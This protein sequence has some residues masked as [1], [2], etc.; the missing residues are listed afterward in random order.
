[1][2]DIE[3]TPRTIGKSGPRVSA[4]TL[5]TSAWRE[6]I[7]AGRDPRAVLDRVLD[8]GTAPW[9]TS[10][11][12]S[13][14]Y[15]DGVS[16]TIIGS[17]VAGTVPESMLIATKLD[18]DPETGDFSGA[19]LRRSLEESLERLGLDRVPVLHLHD[20]NELGYAEAF[21]PNGAIDAIVRMRREG[22][23]DRIGISG[24]W[25]PMLVQ[26]AATGLFDAVVTHNRYTLVDR[27]A[28]GL[29]RL[30][31]ERGI[32]VFNAAPYGSAPLAKWPAPVDRYAY[33]PAHPELAAAVDA[34]GR[35]ALEAGVPLGAA[36][37][38][39]SLRDRR[40]TSTIVGINSLEQLEQTLDWATRPIPDDLWPR[41]EHLV[42]APYT[43][44]EAPGPSPWDDLPTELWKNIDA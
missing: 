25:A 11:D 40:V 20:P 36:A 2:P 9:I 10:V 1:M 15:G 27:S 35:I 23:V 8:G 26:Y 41:L 33:V 32:A 29:L 43:W 7:A 37:L 12:T 5:G 21:A 42:P 44:Q 13:N 18:R 39:F 4:L 6:A 34:M 31:A 3:W 19:R 17:A 30:C 24:A 14:N 38:Q 22:L 28:D 16:E